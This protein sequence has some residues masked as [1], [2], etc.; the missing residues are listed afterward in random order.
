[1]FACCHPVLNQEEQVILTLHTLGGLTIIE[2]ARALLISET[3]VAAQLADAKSKFKA[4]PFRSSETVPIPAEHLISV[5]TVIY[6]IFNE[7]FT[8]TTGDSL[9]RVNLCAEAIRLARTL[10]RVAP[11]EVESHGLLAL[12]LL[13]DSRRDARVDRDGELV[14]LEAQDRSLWHR[15][16]IEEGISLIE[17]FLDLAEPGPFLLQASIAAVHALAETPAETDWRLIAELYAQLLRIAPSPVVELNRAVAVALSGKLEIG[18][19]LIEQ[20]YEV[21]ELR[22]YHLLHAARA[23]ILRRLGRREESA[24]AYRQALTCTRNTAEQRYLSRRL[25]DVTRRLPSINGG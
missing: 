24:N 18:L 22:E 6:L 5:R 2:I 12:M 16:Q 17:N 11:D 14:P 21:D 20:L 23:D 1:M 13:Q 7:G 19:R 8:A 10:C 15:E 9:I 3:A 4:M 25:E